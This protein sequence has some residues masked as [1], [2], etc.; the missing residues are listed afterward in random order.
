MVRGV[1][2]RNLAAAVRGGNVMGHVGESGPDGKLRKACQEFEAYF[3]AQMLKVMR[4][5][6]MQEGFIPKS[7][8]ERIFESQRDIELA[9]EL[10]QR[11]ALG[12]G[13]L[14]YTALSPS[15]TAAAVSD[16]HQ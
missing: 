11:G 2:P 8:G 4:D 5:S 6:G 16:T 9:N 14:L 1:E 12:I 7:S 15:V 13:E 3:T 10:A